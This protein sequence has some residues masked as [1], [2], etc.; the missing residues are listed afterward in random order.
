MQERVREYYC[1]MH[2]NS[3]QTVVLL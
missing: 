3:S 2:K 1:A